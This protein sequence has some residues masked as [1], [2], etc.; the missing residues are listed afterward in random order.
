MSTA[1]TFIH[2]SMA[3]GLIVVAPSFTSLPKLSR[4]QSIVISQMGPSSVHV[5]R[6]WGEFRDT[7]DLTF[8]HVQG[9]VHIEGTYRSSKG[10]ELHYRA[11]VTRDEGHVEISDLQETF[12]VRLAKQDFRGHAYYK[13]VSIGFG[14]KEVAVDEQQLERNLPQLVEIAEGLAQS[15]MLPLILDSHSL[16][17]AIQQKLGQRSAKRA[18]FGFIQ[19]V[20][21]AGCF[22]E[23]ADC[24]VTALAYGLS[25]S[26]L[27]SLCGATIGATCIIAAVEGR[28]AALSIV[29]SCGDCLGC[30][31]S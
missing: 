16:I 22:W 25:I 10:G 13:L 5:E 17:Q 3:T 9:G 12:T 11:E 20:L 24:G 23:C 26:S 4:I 18:S 1:R 2:R 21:A 7:V 31:S 29:L 8:G 19:E 6:T 27:I 14:D 15:R 30:I 28:L